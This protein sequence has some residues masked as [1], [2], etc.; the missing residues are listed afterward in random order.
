M[1][2]CKHEKPFKAKES[3][4]RN[5]RRVQ[6]EWNRLITS[7]IQRGPNAEN[8]GEHATPGVSR[9]STTKI[10]WVFTT[11]AKER[12]L[13]GDMQIFAHTPNGKPLVV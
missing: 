9:I 13:P 6:N 5:V 7:V 2:Q 10:S 4:K 11:T 3:R 8:S 12:T 1:G